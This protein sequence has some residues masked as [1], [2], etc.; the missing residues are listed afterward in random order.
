MSARGKAVEPM[1]DKT[2]PV[3]KA[4]VTRASSEFP[5]VIVFDLETTGLSKEKSRIVEI[6]AQTFGDPKSS[7]TTLVNPGRFTIPSAVTALTGI[8]NSMVSAADI[9]SFAMAAEQL[10]A[11]IDRAREARPGAPVLLVAHNARQFDAA[12]L[13]HEYRRLG[14]ELP[15]SW[16]F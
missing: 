2:S 3:G 10:E 4:A 12:F 13:Q 11:F 15:T 1:V 6:A 16:R 5:T 14:R 9:P 8:T 7:F